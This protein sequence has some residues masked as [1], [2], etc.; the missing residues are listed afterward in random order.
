MSET[1]PVDVFPYTVAEI[2]TLRKQGNH[3]TL[4]ALREGE[5]LFERKG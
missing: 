3:F 5:I 1:S 4:R 2:E